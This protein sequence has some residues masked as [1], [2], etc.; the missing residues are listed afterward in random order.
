MV[1]VVV[2][3]R[4]RMMETTKDMMEKAM[5]EILILTIKKV[6]EMLILTLTMKKMMMKKKMS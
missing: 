3:V 1:V 5:V 2:V 6:M 4:I